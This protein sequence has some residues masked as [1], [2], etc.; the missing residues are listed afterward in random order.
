MAPKCPKTQRQAEHNLSSDSFSFV[1][2]A[3]DVS[4]LEWGAIRLRWR[5][6]TQSTVM[7]LNCKEDKMCSLCLSGVNM[8]TH[9]I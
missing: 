5:E 4:R 6:K 7:I 2:R 8:E 9:E 3:I 1:C